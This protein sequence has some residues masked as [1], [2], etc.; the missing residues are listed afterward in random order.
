MNS[1]NRQLCGIDHDRRVSF[2]HIFGTAMINEG[3]YV[4]TSLS[5]MDVVINISGPFGASKLTDSTLKIVSLLVFDRNTNGFIGIK[6]DI[7]LTSIGIN[8]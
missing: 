8:F 1:R 3:L 7:V 4:G 6:I 2:D 5:V